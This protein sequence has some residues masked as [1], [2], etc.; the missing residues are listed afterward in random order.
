M[1]DPTP[2]VPFG[3]YAGIILVVLMMLTGWVWSRR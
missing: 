3:G 1:F 2:A